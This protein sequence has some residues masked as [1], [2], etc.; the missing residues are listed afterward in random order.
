AIPLTPAQPGDL[1]AL[2]SKSSLEERI[3][4]FITT[5]YLLPQDALI[6]AEAERLGVTAIATLD[7]DWRRVA[8]FDIYTTPV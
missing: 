6:L 3:R 5:Y 2:P 7:S 4:H 1:T 8:E